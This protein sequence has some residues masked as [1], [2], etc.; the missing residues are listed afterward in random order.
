MKDPFIENLAYFRGISY[1][2]AA[3]QHRDDVDID[4]AELAMVL[5]Y[6][7]PEL[8]DV[9]AP[10]FQRELGPSIP[11]PVPVPGPQAPE[12]KPSFIR[13]ALEGL[14][15]KDVLTRTRVNHTIHAENGVMLKV[16][17]LATPEEEE[18]FLIEETEQK[19]TEQQPPHVQKM[20]A[21]CGLDPNTEPKHTVALLQLPPERK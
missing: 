3:K 19:M 6:P 9:Q 20:N 21:M 7:P 4:K 10:I 15:M 14:F 16:P 2:E 8:S 5:G 17:R 1:E 13:R 18:R 12:F 11:L